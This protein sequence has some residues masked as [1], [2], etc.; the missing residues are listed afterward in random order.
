MTISVDFLNYLPLALF[1]ILLTFIMI[2]TVNS[3]GSVSRGYVTVDQL[4]STTNLGYNIFYRILSPT[5]FISFATLLLYKVGLSGLTR[6][7]W[8]VAVYFLIINLLTLILMQ[9]FAL[10]NKFLYGLIQVLSIVIA[11]WVYDNA[12]KYGPSAILP[13]SGNFRTELWFIIIAYFYS[14]LNNFSPNHYAEFERKKNYLSNRF[15]VLNNKYGSLLKKNFKE[16]KFLK[17]IFFAIMITEDMNRPPFIRWLERLI[18]PLGIVKTTGVMQV[19][20]KTPLTDEQSVS[21]AQELILKSYQKHHSTTGDEN[22][23]VGEIAND[24]NHGGYGV[25]IKR[26]YWELKNII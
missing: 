18:F 1:Q 17:H 24:Y 26:Y 13:E 6:D 5:I 10:V 8:L 2:I 11:F 21:M 19:T 23:L 14:L 15:I 7:I 3:F 4:L 9:R 12:L 25:D 22:L 20:N 16:N